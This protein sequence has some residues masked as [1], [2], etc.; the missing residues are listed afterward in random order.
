[1]K[2]YVSL[3]LLMMISNLATGQAPEM[4]KELEYTAF[5]RGYS[6][7]IRA[8][9]DSIT[10]EEKGHRGNTH[11]SAPITEDQWNSLVQTLK[12]VP[13]EELAQLPSPTN[14]RQRDA[15][16]HAK[17]SITTNAGNYSST[18]FDS[19]NPPKRLALLVEQLKKLSKK[20]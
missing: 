17:V 15:A 10:R 7:L 3:L 20:E 16:L 18:E 14:D 2:I 19:N 12:E 5:T 6:E 13:L 4:V 8:T 11:T 1:M 9:K